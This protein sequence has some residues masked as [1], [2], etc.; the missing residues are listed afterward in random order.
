MCSTSNT[1]PDFVQPGIHP[2]LPWFSVCSRFVI[3]K[4]YLILLLFQHQYV[5]HYHQLEQRWY[6][7]ATVSEEHQMRGAV[8]RVCVQC[9]RVCVSESIHR[10]TL[11]LHLNVIIIVQ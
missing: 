1:H 5:E 8:R 3:V 6:D 2:P 7:T 4:Y 9:K 10:S 11:R